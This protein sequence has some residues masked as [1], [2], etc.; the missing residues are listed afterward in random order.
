MTYEVLEDTAFINAPD[1]W[2]KKLNGLGRLISDGAVVPRAF[3]LGPGIVRELSHGAL[4]DPL[5]ADIDARASEISDEWRGPLI[6]RFSGEVGAEVRPVQ[7]IRSRN[8][9]R[10]ALRHLCADVQPRRGSVVIQRHWNSR[11]A[12]ALSFRGNTDYLIRA[13]W[14]QHLALKLEL[15]PAD[16]ASAYGV[17]LAEKTIAVLLAEE[18]WWPGDTVRLPGS[19]APDCT[20]LDID[21]TENVA[22]CLVGPEVRD[23]P[24]LSDVMIE[25]LLNIA[26]T[27][28]RS[29]AQD[30][31]FDW[32]HDGHEMVVLNLST[33]QSIVTEPG[34]LVPPHSTVSLKGHPASRGVIEG[35]TVI[36]YPQ[37][38]LE[39]AEVEGRVLVMAEPTPQHTPLLVAAS[40][41]VTEIGNNLCHAAIVA[42]E[43][44]IPAVVGVAEAMERLKANSFVRVDGDEGTIEVLESTAKN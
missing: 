10:R 28:R 23:R 31:Q 5:R 1:G 44:G 4:R 35:L 7:N 43:V 15:S 14:G 40:A 22:Y 12:G 21:E 9:F 19:V 29:G 26:E 11:V 8:R 32:A 33:E 20:V 30:V 37:Q 34:D 24:T 18:D 16:M 6:C 36:L 38:E 3:A 41:I 39:V 2:G 13:V 25:E 27:I 17:M 42:R